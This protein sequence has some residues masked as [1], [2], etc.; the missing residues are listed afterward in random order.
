[1]GKLDEAIVPPPPNPLPA[2]FPLLCPNFVQEYI[3]EFAQEVDILELVQAIFYT[4]TASYAN[5]LGVFQK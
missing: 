4:M 1:M 3:K 2:Y 5:E